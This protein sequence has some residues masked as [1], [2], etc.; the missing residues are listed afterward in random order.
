[1]NF[2]KDFVQEL[3]NREKI[4]K[5]LQHENQ[6]HIQEKAILKEKNRLALNDVQKLAK[7]VS[8]LEEQLKQRSA[9]EH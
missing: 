5:V 2:E 4:I 7:K 1:M 8:E 3:D 6:N 9:F